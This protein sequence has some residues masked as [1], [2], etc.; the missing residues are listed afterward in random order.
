MKLDAQRLARVQADR[1][2]DLDTGTPTPRAERSGS[3]RALPSDAAN[4]TGE[5]CSTYRVAGLNL[6]EALRREAPQTAVVPHVQ[7]DRHVPQ[8]GPIHQASGTAERPPPR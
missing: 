1:G 6:A 7:P 2:R 5:G 4:C 3:K 8:P